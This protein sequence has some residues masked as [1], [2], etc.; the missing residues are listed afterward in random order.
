[1]VAYSNRHKIVPAINNF[2]NFLGSQ[3]AY[4]WVE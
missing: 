2:R 4:A 1:V 3:F